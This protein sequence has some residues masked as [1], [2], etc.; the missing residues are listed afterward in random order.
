VNFTDFKKYI[1]GS[2]G[3]FES[4]PCVQRRVPHLA[5]EQRMACK[6]RGIKEEKKFCY[7]VLRR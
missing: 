3:L 4:M 1:C 7:Q 2:T 5:L 6:L